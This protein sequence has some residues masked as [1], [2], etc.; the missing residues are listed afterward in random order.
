MTIRSGWIDETLDERI[1][2]VLKDGGP[3]TVGAVRRA[4]VQGRDSPMMI[5]TVTQRMMALR[6]QGRVKSEG[7]SHGKQVIRHWSRA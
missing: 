6:R 2:E 7:K 1:L 5:Q 3:M 4:L